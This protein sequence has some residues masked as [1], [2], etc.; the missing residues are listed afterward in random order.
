MNTINNTN[1]RQSSYRYNNNVSF[2]GMR[3]PLKN[4]RTIS[5]VLG[6]KALDSEKIL[7]N[8]HILNLSPEKV[9]GVVKNAS[10][11]RLMFFDALVDRYNSKNYFAKTGKE[12]PQEVLDI[13]QMVKKPTPA[14]YEISN[15]SLFTVCRF[16]YYNTSARVGVFT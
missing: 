9:E 2:Q 8:S 6:K 10:K 16:T 15:H 1:F 13:F 5:S 12:N 4:I 7:N 11:K 3:N 14:H